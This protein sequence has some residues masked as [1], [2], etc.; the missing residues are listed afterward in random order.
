MSAPPLRARIEQVAQTVSEEIDGKDYDCEA[1]TGGAKTVIGAIARYKRELEIMLPQ[2]GILEGTPTPR[3][4]NPA[5]LRIA[6]AQTM[7]LWTINGGIVL[8]KI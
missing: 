1:D 4:L 8:G 6:S 2:L 3:K 5:S 7:A